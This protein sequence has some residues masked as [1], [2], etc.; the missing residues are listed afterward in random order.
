MDL[1]DLLKRALAE[2]KHYEVCVISHHDPAIR[3]KHGYWL[4]KIGHDH[5]YYENRRGKHVLYAADPQFFDKLKKT[6][7]ELCRRD[8]QY[9]LDYG[10]K[11]RKTRGQS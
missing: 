6:L 5:V 7:I 4:C 11:L 2:T 1:I 9:W 3:C 10:R 8:H